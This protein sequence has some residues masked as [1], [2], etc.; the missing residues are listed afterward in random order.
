MPQGLLGVVVLPSQG[1]KRREEA[2]ASLRPLGS[3][4]NSPQG[5]LE[6]LSRLLREELNTETI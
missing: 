6:L 2:W 5:L 1:Q 4:S 3:S